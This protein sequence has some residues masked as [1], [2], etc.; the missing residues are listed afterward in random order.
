MNEPID[1]MG[2]KMK[3]E[4]SPSCKL[5]MDDGSLWYK[6]SADYSFPE[7]ACVGGG[8]FSIEFW[9]R[10]EAEAI[11]RITAMRSTLGEPRQIYDEIY[12]G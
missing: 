12:N 8:T 3:R 1:F 2:E 7:G 9:A 10:N 4:V 6:F 5:I 11:G